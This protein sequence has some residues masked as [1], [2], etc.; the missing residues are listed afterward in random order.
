M[1]VLVVEGEKRVVRKLERALKRIDQSIH[2]IGTVPA[3]FASAHWL[4]QHGVPDIILMSEDAVKEYQV[5]DLSQG[6]M[7]ATVIFTVQSDQF[8]F[9][10]FRIGHLEHLLPAAFMNRYLEEA[11]TEI[12]PP[13]QTTTT[14][15]QGMTTA[16]R[17]RFLVKQGQKFAS[18][19]TA[20][21]AYFFSEGRFIFFKTFDG[22]KYL[23]EYTLEELETMLDPQLFFRINRSLL[24]AFKCV[25]QIHPYFGNRLKL[26]LDPTMEKDILVS[27]EKVN[28]FKKWLG[29]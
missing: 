2:I 23:V 29:Q 9:Y 11:Y 3:I 26:F 17:T 12:L 24:I 18:V 6:K 1:K 28:E 19:E 27:R 8:T 22:Q 16:W 13:T 25:E 20:A 7:N 14:T 21:I 5:V 15:L 10:A 4:E